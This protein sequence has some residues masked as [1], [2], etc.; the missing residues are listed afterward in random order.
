MAAEG[1]PISDQRS[2]AA[3]RTAM[4]GRSLL[5]LFEEVAA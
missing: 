1:T 2:S 3:Y 4:L 5:K